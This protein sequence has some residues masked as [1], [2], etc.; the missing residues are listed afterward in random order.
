MKAKTVYAIG[1]LAAIVLAYLIW[2]DIANSEDLKN[3]VAPIIIENT[4]DLPKTACPPNSTSYACAPCDAKAEGMCCICRWCINEKK[5]IG[6][7]LRGMYCYPC[8]T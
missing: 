1:W 3:E 6:Q 2:T 4:T 5:P 8:S 7:D